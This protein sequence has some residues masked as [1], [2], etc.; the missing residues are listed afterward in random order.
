MPLVNDGGL[1]LW[2]LE[3]ETLA[4]VID[5]AEDISNDLSDDGTT[6]LMCIP[7][8]IMSYQRNRWLDQKCKE[9]GIKP[10]HEN[11]VRAALHYC[12]DFG[13]TERGTV[14]ILD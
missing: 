8:V 3:P 10:T 5:V 1:T 4:E 14:Y 12:L 7:M 11:V 13:I 9:A 6:V 2:R